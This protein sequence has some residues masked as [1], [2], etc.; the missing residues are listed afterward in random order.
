MTSFGIVNKL[1][2]NLFAKHANGERSLLG[3]AQRAFVQERNI[4]LAQHGWDPVE[5]QDRVE[6]YVSDIE[7]S[8]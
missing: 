6:E 2:D 8:E 1:V 3:G 5:F 4:L 7:V